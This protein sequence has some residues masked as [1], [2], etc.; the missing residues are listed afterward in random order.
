[1]PTNSDLAHVSEVVSRTLACAV[2][3]Q[4]L[5]DA[6]DPTVP[7]PIRLD[8][9]AFIAGDERYQT[10]CRTAGMTPRPLYRPRVA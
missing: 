7:D 1:M 2:I 9:Q 5:A 6:L 8:A 10:W 4:A 3:K